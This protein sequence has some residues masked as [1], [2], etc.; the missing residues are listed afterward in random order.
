VTTRLFSGS[1]EFVPPERPARS[2]IGATDEE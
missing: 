1:D 2:G